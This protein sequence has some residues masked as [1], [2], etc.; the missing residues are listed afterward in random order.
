MIE[1]NAVISGA[2]FDLERG[3]SAWVQL[4]Y[5]D[6]GSQGFG[7]Y[8]LYAPEGWKAHKSGG[9]YAGHFIYRVLTI[10]GASD[11]S[12]LVGRTVRARC[13]HSKVYA[14]GHIVKD[15]WF[16]PSADFDAIRKLG[17][18]AVS[19]DQKPRCRHLCTCGAILICGDP[20]KCG[21]GAFWRCFA[22]ELD[23]YDDYL[24]RR[25]TTE[26]EHTTDE[27]QQRIPEQVSQS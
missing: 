13:D 4:D 23:H 11:W 10:A 15:D 1:R 7:G 18:R 20:D 2:S 17:G 14:I 16:D 3:L 8:L 6:S 12:K 5:G 9:N 26:Q 21:A 27:H 25:L 24:N 19:T 22:C